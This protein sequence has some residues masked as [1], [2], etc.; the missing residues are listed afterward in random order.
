[1]ASDRIRGD[2]AVDYFGAL[3]LLVF[4][5]ASKSQQTR[6]RRRPPQPGTPP[7][8]NRMN[9][10]SAVTAAR[11]D[12]KTGAHDREAPRVAESD[13]PAAR[14]TLSERVRRSRLDVSVALQDT[15]WGRVAPAAA[16]NH[17]GKNGAKAGCFLVLVIALGLAV[18]WLV[19]HLHL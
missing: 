5:L 13:A 1:M 7:A 2:V 17:Y 15:R 11:R 4:F 9:L 19:S 18:I 14:R 6:T 3:A 12:G 16:G 8:K 10:R